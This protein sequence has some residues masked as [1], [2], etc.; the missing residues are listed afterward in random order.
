MALDVR[1]VKGMRDVLPEEIAAWHYLEQHLRQLS[2]RYGYSEIRLPVVEQTALFYRAI[3]EITD[4]VEKE[5]YTF[6]DKGGES[7]TLR[8]EST[9]QCVRAVLENNLIR[10]QTPKLWYLGPMFRRENPQKGRYRQFYQFGIEAFG[11]PGPDVDVEQLVMMARLWKELGIEQKIVLKINSLGALEERRLYREAL[12]AYLESQYSNLNEEGRRRLRTNPLRVLDSKDPSM[13]SVIAQAPN[14]LE[15][16]GEHSLRHF[17]LIQQGLK[18]CGVVFEI[19]HR[20]VRGLDYYS[21][22][23]YEWITQDLGAQGT[24]CGGGRYNTLVETLGGPET[25]AVGFSLGID[26]LVMLL[27]EA[28]RV[29]QKSE[30]DVYFIVEG[31][32][33]QQRAMAIAE[34]VRE[35]F[36]AISLYVHC[37]GGS[38]KSQFKR[39]DKCGAR[40]ALIMGDEEESNGMLGVKALRTSGGEQQTLPIEQALAYL[41]R[42]LN[43]DEMA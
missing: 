33:A 11:L 22:T 32:R 4:I 42:Q 26:R 36:P 20:L 6:T 39:A 31:E 14:M 7:L 10:H 16:L 34:R 18:Q 38:F 21:H 2:A 12:V 25:P 40:L 13:A 19:D 28:E 27:V 9:A 29:P 5:M 35:A 3:G 30:V 43:R 1:I 24:V 15:F 8:P 37:G 17:D 23:V 41:E